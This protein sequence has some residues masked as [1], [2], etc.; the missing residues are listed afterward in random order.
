M[1]RW[2][3]AANSRPEALAVAPLVTEAKIPYV[4]FNG[5]TSFIVD[6]SPYLVRVGFTIW[7]PNV[8][9]AEYAVTHGCKK[10]T[11]IVADYAP[12]EDTVDALTYG[13]EKGGGKI[14]D[15]IKVP[16]GTTDFSAYMQRLQGFEAAMRDSRS[17]R[18]ARCR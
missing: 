11:L 1:P 15:V 13:F 6:K 4:I 12:G 3:A 14:A 17:C 7:Q 16:L 8:P 9:L 10:V 5:A 18:A 2:S